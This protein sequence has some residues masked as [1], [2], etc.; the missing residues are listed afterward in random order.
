VRICTVSA[1]ALVQSDAHFQ[2]DAENLP[3]LTLPTMAAVLSSAQ[4]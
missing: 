2:I 4:I 3:V 1:I